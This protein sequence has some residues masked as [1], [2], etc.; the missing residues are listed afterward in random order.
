[1]KLIIMFLLIYHFYY[2]YF[3]KDFPFDCYF[4]VLFLILMEL[5]S[6]YFP[7]IPL[8]INLMENKIKSKAIKLLIIQHLNKKVI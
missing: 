5:L 7:N 3:I 2:Y 8:F 6:H 4:I 1:M